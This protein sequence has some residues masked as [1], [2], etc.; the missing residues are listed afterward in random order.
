MGHKKPVRKK[1][2]A[3][4][5]IPPKKAEKSEAAKQSAMV[6]LLDGSVKRNSVLKT[7]VITG[8][9]HSQPQS[10]DI[11]IG[12]FSITNFGRELVRDTTLEINFGRRYGLIGWTEVYGGVM[13]LEE[14]LV[15]E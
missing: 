12:S 1:P 8:E 14:I 13:L 4:P 10:R 2:G 11:K 6:E 15:V 7:A 3:A 5:P 9:L